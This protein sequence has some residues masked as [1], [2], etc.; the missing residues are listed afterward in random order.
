VPR[1]L[2]QYR[3][4]IGSPGGL[5]LERQKFRAKLQKFNSVHTE[6]FKILFQPV[7]W[8]ETLRGAGRTQALI[9]KDLEEC[10]Y[11][12]FILHDRWGTS[13]GDENKEFTSGTDEEWNLAQRLYRNSM[14]KN[15]LLFFKNVENSQLRNPTP[16]LRK[17]LSFRKQIEKEK[18]HFFQDYNDADQFID[19][20]DVQLA[21]WLN[22]HLSNLGMQRA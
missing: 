21:N 5:E 14:M 15:V 1:T 2:T 22:D 4:F 12:V 9:D 19:T 20:L 3:V 16:Q 17:V 18:K 13:P 8:E 11:A 10:D 6:I 7:C